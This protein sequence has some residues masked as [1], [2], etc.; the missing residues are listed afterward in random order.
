VLAEAPVK[1]D[2]AMESVIKQ[3]G[4]GGAKSSQATSEGDSGSNAANNEGNEK[5]QDTTD[6]QDH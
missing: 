6:G 4:E 3:F 1:L 2:A 5:A